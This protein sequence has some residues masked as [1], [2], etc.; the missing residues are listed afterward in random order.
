[1]LEYSIYRFCRYML[2]F[3]A[4]KR[5]IMKFEMFIDLLKYLYSVNV[6]VYKVILIK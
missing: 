2:R 5:I 1:M 3:R 6:N 4:V